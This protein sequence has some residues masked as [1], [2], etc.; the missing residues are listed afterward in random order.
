MNTPNHPHSRSLE[1]LYR[2]R[3][4]MLRLLLIVTIGAAVAVV[5]YYL[6]GPQT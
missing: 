2:H 4:I 1:T 3:R 5:G 6:V